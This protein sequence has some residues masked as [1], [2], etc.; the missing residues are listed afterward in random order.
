MVSEGLSKVVTFELRCEQEAAD[1]DVRKEHSKPRD[2]SPEALRWVG[3]CE[4]KKEGTGEHWG[5]EGRKLRQVT[6]AWA[7]T[8]RSV[9]SMDF[10]LLTSYCKKMSSL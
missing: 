1:E 5:K 7:S 8:Y 9:S 10:F 2:T 4:G 3:E 6:R